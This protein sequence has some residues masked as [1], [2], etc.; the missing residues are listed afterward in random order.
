MSKLLLFF[1]VLVALDLCLARRGYRQGR[2]NR[3][4]RQRQRA[5]YSFDDD[6]FGR[7]G[8]G[9]HHQWNRYV[10]TLFSLTQIVRPV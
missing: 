1:I 4:Q 2:P 8:H 5:G 6:F 7:G 3:R 10:D 9:R